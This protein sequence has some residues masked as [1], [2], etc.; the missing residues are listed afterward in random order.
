MRNPLSNFKGGD[1]GDQMA[2]GYKKLRG[3]S[4]WGFEGRMDE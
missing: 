3:E 4:G 2:V 1:A